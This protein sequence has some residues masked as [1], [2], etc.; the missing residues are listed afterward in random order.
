MRAKSYRPRSAWR[1]ALIAAALTNGACDTVNEIGN[2][3]DDADVYYYL[4][5]GTSLSVG[6]QPNSNGVL[7]PT[8]DGYADQLFASIKPAFDAAGAQA[9][10]LELVKLG[11]PGET[12]DDMAN[13][14]NCLYVEGSQLEAAVDFLTA[15]SGNVHLVTIDMGANDFRDG[16]CID[17]MVDLVCVNAVSTQISIDLAAVLATLRNAAGPD[18]TIVG[19]NY[20]NPFLASWLLDLAGQTLAMES[21]QAVSVLNGFL[22]TTYAAEGMPLADVAFAF[23]SDDFSIGQSLLPINVEN[24]CELTY[25]CDPPPVGPDI[26]AKPAGYSLI[27]DT[28][29]AVL[30]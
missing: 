23:E 4:S 10:D 21:A 18:T 9:R 2:I 1:I 14:G 3:G 25:A 12:L 26:H 8:G 7:L 20:Y 27:A 24:I 28:F 16:G 17:T 30:P 29:A 13:G 11:C 5:L 19:M 15:N 22:D 6:V